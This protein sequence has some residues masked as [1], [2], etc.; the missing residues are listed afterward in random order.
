[1]VPKTDEGSNPQHHSQMGLLWLK[2]GEGVISLQANKHSKPYPSQ[3][4]CT[5]LVSRKNEISQECSML[6]HVVH[7]WI[8]DGLSVHHHNQ[9]HKHDNSSLSLPLVHILTVC[10]GATTNLATNRQ[11]G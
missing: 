5:G 1:M 7:S 11:R 3:P 6:S 10:G 9:V 4:W 2:G 8:T